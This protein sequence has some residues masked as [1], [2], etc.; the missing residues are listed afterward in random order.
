MLQQRG[1]RTVAQQ[2]KGVFDQREGRLASEEFRVGQRHRGLGQMEN[3]REIK[4]A[5]ILF[6][7]RHKFR[8]VAEKLKRGAWLRRTDLGRRQQVRLDGVSARL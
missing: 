6:E 3:V 1:R 8:D 7:R 2:V 4:V 5:V